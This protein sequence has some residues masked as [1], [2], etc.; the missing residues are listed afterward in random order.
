MRAVLLAWLRDRRWRRDTLARMR[1]TAVVEVAEVAGVRVL[2]PLV[3][4]PERRLV[5]ARS[6]GATVEVVASDAPV[7]DLIAALDAAFAASLGGAADPMGTVHEGVLAGLGVRSD[8]ALQQRGLLVHLTRE[9]DGEVQLEP[10]YALSGG[11]TSE[12]EQRIT[13]PPGTSSIDVAEA[14]VALHDDMATRRPR[15]RKA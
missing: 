14:V 12:P 8:R 10:M 15:A 5:A 13:F 4:H 1:A 11:W 3:P 6:D 2:K 7:A 9:P